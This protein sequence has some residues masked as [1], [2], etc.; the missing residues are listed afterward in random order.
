MFKPIGPDR[1]C[2]MQSCRLDATEL[3]DIS[4][5]IALPD[6]DMPDVL[7]LLADDGA[8]DGDLLQELENEQQQQQQACGDAS[9]GLIWPEMACRNNVGAGPPAAAAAAAAAG[10]TAGMPQQQQ[11]AVA[12]FD[13]STHAAAAADMMSLSAAA[14][15]AAAGA[16]GQFGYQ[17]PASTLEYASY[18]ATAASADALGAP[19]VNPWWDLNTYPAAASQPAAAAAIIK[20]EEWSLTAVDST[21][22]HINKAPSRTRGAA[23]AAAA[24][25]QGRGSKA[26]KPKR[27]PSEAQRQAHKRFRER[28]KTQ[29]R[30]Q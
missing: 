21:A 2:G 29:V 7:S 10:P 11:A 6:M 15:A 23:V 19:Q 3:E 25:P 18:N 28:R 24:A 16:S 14:A 5:C 12:Q 20:A 26:V 8:A 1:C 4:S 13:A 9:D 17:L 27:K 22:M 30:Q